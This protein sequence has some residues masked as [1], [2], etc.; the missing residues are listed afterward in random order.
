MEA[1]MQILKKTLPGKRSKQV[2][3]N[4]LHLSSFLMA[5]PEQ[6]TN[7]TVNTN[8][9]P[10]NYLSKAPLFISKGFLFCTHGSNTYQF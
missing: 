6:T 8:Y 1:E 7:F 3:R 5:N 4:L 9:T 10:V 2:S